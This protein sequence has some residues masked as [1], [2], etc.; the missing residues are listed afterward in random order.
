MIRV[1][2]TI[3]QQAGAAILLGRE[4]GTEQEQPQAV[5]MLEVGINRNRL[6]FGAAHE[7]ITGVVSGLVVVDFKK[8]LLTPV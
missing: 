4:L 2:V 7:V 8:G 6:D 1:V 3:T 5:G